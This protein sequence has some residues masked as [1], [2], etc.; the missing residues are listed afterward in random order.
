MS[1]DPSAPPAPSRVRVI[2]PAFYRGHATGSLAPDVRDALIGCTTQADDEGWLLWDLDDVATTLYPYLP[3]RRRRIDLERRAE[4]LVEAGLLVIEP[5][6]CA[7]LP[8]LKEHHGIKGGRPTSQVWAWHQ[9]HVRA[10]AGTSEHAP[11]SVSSS[12]SVSSAVQGSSSS[13][14][15]ATTSPEHPCVDCPGGP[16]NSH[17][18]WCVQV[19]H[20]QLAVVQ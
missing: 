13:R 10:R 4:R 11:S 3:A 5:C 16:E 2:R 6:G 18:K 8:S 9:S 7:F 15:P 19:R 1:G 20:P 14:A 17:A 12:S